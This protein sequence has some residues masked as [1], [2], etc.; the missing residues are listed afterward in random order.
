MFSIDGVC[1]HSYEI[2]FSYE[3]PS[4]SDSVNS[5]A[6]F[7]APSRA[8]K[9]YK[10]LLN[11]LRNKRKQLFDQKRVSVEHYFET[12]TLEKVA[13]VAAMTVPAF[14]A[15][16]KK[17][18]R[19]TYIEFLTDVRISNACKLLVETDDCINDICYS[20]GFNTLTNFNRQFHKVKQLTPSIYRKMFRNM[21]VT[22]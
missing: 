19:K 13:S 16:F 15:Y 6:S 7:F 21:A 9:E 14:C 1:F 18:T 20:C 17:T 2:I 10:K 12:I 4:L 5:M 22:L 8:N 11:E 3:K